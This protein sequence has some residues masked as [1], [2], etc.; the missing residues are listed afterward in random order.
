MTDQK[1]VEADFECCQA[2][3]MLE[4]QRLDESSERRGFLP[5][6]T[7]GWREQP[8]SVGKYCMISNHKAGGQ[9]RICDEVANELRAGTTE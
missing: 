6:E 1:S 8:S 9:G 3:R 5:N 4:I 2:T 7:F